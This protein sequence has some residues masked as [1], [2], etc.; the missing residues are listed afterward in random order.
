MSDDDL[1]DRDATLSHSYVGAPSPM[2]VSIDAENIEILHPDKH[3]AL[4]L[5][6]VVIPLASIALR[7]RLRCDRSTFSPN[8]RLFVSQWRWTSVCLFF[9]L[10]KHFSHQDFI[11]I[12]CF[13]TS[14]RQRGQPSAQTHVFPRQTAAL[15]RPQRPRRPS[16]TAQ[17]NPGQRPCCAA[18]PGRCGV[19][20]SQPDRAAVLEHSGA[21]GKTDQHWRST[22]SSGPFTAT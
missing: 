16:S 14:D 8:P 17:A 13:F 18:A 9:F 15:G 12:W 5:R 7:S 21:L 4:A 10:Q 2:K 19:A 6:P 11:I 1:D 20:E 3:S 22:Q